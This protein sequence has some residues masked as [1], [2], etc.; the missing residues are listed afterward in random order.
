MAEKAESSLDLGQIEVELQAGLRPPRETAYWLLSV[1]RS[2]EAERDRY[3]AAL[4]EI[5]DKESTY[6]SSWDATVDVSV[7]DLRDIAR[8][9]LNGSSPPEAK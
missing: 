6:L 5:R 4:E 1:V 9:A 7:R 8:H 2:A 3:K